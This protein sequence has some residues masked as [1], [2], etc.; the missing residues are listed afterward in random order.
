MRV[1]AISGFSGTGKTTIVEGLVRALVESGYTVA[2][3]KSS[4][5]DPGPESGTDTWKHRQAGA[6]V[7][8]FL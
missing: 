8:L 3:I 5:H 4:K 6:S 2:T 1:F 7:A